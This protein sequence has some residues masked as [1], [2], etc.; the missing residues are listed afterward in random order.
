MKKGALFL[1]PVLL[2]ACVGFIWW[3]DMT[4]GTR[5]HTVRVAF[6]QPDGTPAAGLPLIGLIDTASDALGAWGQKQRVTDAQGVCTFH[7]IVPGSYW[8]RAGETV[9]TV[10][11]AANAPHEVR[12]SFTNAPDP[13]N[14]TLRV[15]DEAG[16]PAAQ[17]QALIY[18][19]LLECG[20]AD[21]P[22]PLAMQTDWQGSLLWTG[23][24]AGGHVVEIGGARYP[25][26]LE[27]NENKMPSV[28]LTCGGQPQAPADRAVRILRGGGK[29]VPD[30]VV[31]LVEYGIPSGKEFLLRP[32]RTDAQGEFLLTDVAP[33]RVTL[34]IGGKRYK[35]NIPADGDG[36]LEL[37]L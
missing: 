7:G 32:F 11:F 8:L 35:L 4:A 36:V 28:T 21:A 2:A 10:E 18:P 31:D 23:A 22:A 25:L 16:R 29:P 3:H 37:L 19:R 27:P 6:T 14:V 33:G 34:R 15:R 17:A 26:I 30:T 12:F 1:I 5:A 20:A 24:G 9:Y 13:Y